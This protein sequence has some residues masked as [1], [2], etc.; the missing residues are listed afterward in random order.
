M[1]KG[2]AAVIIVFLLLLLNGCGKAPE[3]GQQATAS[4]LQRQSASS[5]ESQEMVYFAITDRLE[6]LGSI[7]SLHASIT[8]LSVE[9]QGQLI[10][11]PV[12]Q[13]AIDIIDLKKRGARLLVAQKLLPEGTYD[14]IRLKLANI[15]INKI[16]PAVMPSSEL[17]F[18]KQFE[19]KK[20]LLQIFLFDFQLEESI[21]AT[22][23]G[24]YIFAPVIEL[25][26]ITG[27][28]IAVSTARTLSIENEKVAGKQKFG[29]DETGAFGT[30][31]RISFDAML[32]LDNGK[33]LKQKPRTAQPSEET[34]PIAAVDKTFTFIMKNLVLNPNNIEIAE[35]TF[36]RFILT[37]IDKPY[38]L[39]IEGY[40]LEVDIEP[41]KESYLDF[42]ADK[43]GIFE[44]KCSQY[45]Y[46]NEGKLL[47]KISVV[48]ARK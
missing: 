26:T 45:C 25:Q 8:Q 14:R 42:K 6:N 34:P 5:Q 10:D 37:S 36:A 33:V 18:E 39:R 28:D 22:V 38:G 31:K 12:S 16:E 32:Y 9:K 19:A 24:K 44:M 47:G 3:T 1:K 27:K 30:E 43:K 29:M 13:E 2:A 35:G 46:G 17:V 23:D 20:N 48:P 41:G 4:T 15:T 7:G 11:I 21:H 40:E